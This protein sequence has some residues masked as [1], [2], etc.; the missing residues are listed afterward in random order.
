M[1]SLFAKCSIFHQDSNKTTVFGYLQL[2]RQVAKTTVDLPP[3]T[4]EFVMCDNKRGFYI[5]IQGKPTQIPRIEFQFEDSESCVLEDI[6]LEFP[7]EDCDL[8]LDPN[9][10][11]IISTM[12]KN[13]SHR[14]EEW[15]EYHL[16]LGF[17]GIV[18][19]DND[20]NIESKLNESLDHCRREQSM[21][22]ICNKYKGKVIRIDC[23]YVSAPGEDWNNIQRVTLNIGVSAFR[24]RC[25]FIALTDADEFIYIPS[26]PHTNIEDFLSRYD[27]TVTMVSKLVT[28]IQDNE[29]IDNNALEIGRYMGDNHYQKTILYTQKIKENEFLNSPHDHEATHKVVSQDEI[30]HYHFWLNGRH[31]WNGNMTRIDFL[32]D[33]LHG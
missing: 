19:F 10:S 30:L 31:R 1:A 18:I 3:L 33:F 16:K 26:S 12:C 8:S 20:G 4:Y 24:T 11:A 13:Y 23:P 5:N 17:S 14:L 22:D 9:H 25:K 7:F 21:A 15:I 32:Y 29:Y 2:F 27:H 6:A 28:N